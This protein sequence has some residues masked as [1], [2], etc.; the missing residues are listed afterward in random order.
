MMTK[1]GTAIIGSAALLNACEITDRT[2][3]DIKVVFTGAGAAAIATANMLVS[4]GVS[5]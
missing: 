1:H 4:L 5:K 3:S 2:L